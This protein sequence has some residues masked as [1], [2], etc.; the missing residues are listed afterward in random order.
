MFPF[1]ALKHVLGQGRSDWSAGTLDLPGG[2][3]LVILN[4]TQ[5]RL[6]V[7]STLMEEICHI[8]LGHSPSRL[9]N[10][11]GAVW[12]RSCDRTIEDEAYR[13]GAACLVPYQGLRMLLDQQCTIPVIGQRFDVST[14][15]VEYRLKLS[16]LWKMYGRMAKQNGAP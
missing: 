12:F 1:E 7:K 6:R 13:L 9:E 14:E 11:D 3:H 8:A 4:P 15:L 2:I 16:G 5:S 10:G